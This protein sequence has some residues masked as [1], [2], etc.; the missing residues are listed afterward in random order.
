[1]VNINPSALMTTPL[2]VR[3]NPKMPAVNASSGTSARSFTT[4]RLIPSTSS[5]G[6]AAPEIQLTS[7]LK[8][9]S[10]LCQVPLLKRHDPTLVFRVSARLIMLRQDTGLVVL[11]DHLVP[12]PGILP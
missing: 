3:C 6:I 8:R 12:F 11:R 10:E 1:M 2:P 7:Q 5:P 4:D 9:M